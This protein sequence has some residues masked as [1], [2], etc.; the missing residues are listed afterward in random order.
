M[1]QAK[2]ILMKILSSFMPFLK[3]KIKTGS[4][5]NYCF[6]DEETIIKRYLSILPVTNTFCVDIAASDGISM[7]NTYSLY[8]SGWDGIAVELDSIKFASLSNTYK[9]FERVSLIKTKVIPGNII[10]LL[11]ACECPTDFQFLNFD[12]DSYDYFVLEHWLVNFG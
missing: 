9:N 10:S 6:L 4:K 11:K 8:K 1:Q 5:N 2:I 12:I 7:S 3:N